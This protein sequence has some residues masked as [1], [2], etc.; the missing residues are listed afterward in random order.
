MAHARSTLSLGRTAA[1]AAGIRA[2]FILAP[3]I[4]AVAIAPTPS[5]GQTPE[6]QR[7]LAVYL[8]AVDFL[9]EL[10]PVSVVDSYSCR[11]SWRREYGIPIRCPS[12]PPLR[13]YLRSLAE[14]LRVPLTEDVPECGV[15]QGRTVRSLAL[16]PVQIVSGRSAWFVISSSCVGPGDSVEELFLVRIRLEETGWMLETTQPIGPRGT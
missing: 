13:T 9:R 2:S 6:A 10:A 3:F 16:S 8:A 5:L 11:T 4:V 14:E 7:D 12:R 1:S 15:D